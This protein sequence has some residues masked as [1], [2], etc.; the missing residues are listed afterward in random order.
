MKKLTTKQIQKMLA[1]RSQ[2][3]KEVDEFFKL[4]KS[5]INKMLDKIKE[6]EKYFK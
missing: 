2:E 6:L 1:K 5:N 3:W 4:R